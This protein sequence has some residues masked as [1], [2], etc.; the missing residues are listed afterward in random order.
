MA[1]LDFEGWDEYSLTNAPGMFN[2]NNASNNSAVG[3]G[4]LGYGRHGVGGTAAAGTG[5]NFANQ[6]AVFANFHFR[7][8]VAPGTGTFFWFV[9]AANVQV[10]LRWS[11]GGNLVLVRGTTIV[12]TSPAYVYP[13]NTWIFLQFYALIDPLVGAMEAW[14]NGVSA[15]SFAGNTRQTANTQVTGWRYSFTGNNNTHFDNL[16]VYNTA[17]AAPNARTQET[18]VFYSL[19]SGPVAGVPAQFTPVGAAANWECTDDNPPDADAT[20]VEAAAAPLTDVYDIPANAV[21][22]GSTVY[23]VANR[24]YARK[25]DAGV[26]DLDLLLR[27][28]GVNYP[29]GAPVALNTAYTIQRSVWNTD[30]NTVAAWTVSGA[31]AALPGIT[32]TA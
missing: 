18:R 6:V 31:N 2:V 24:A 20:Y 32:R 21:P 14:V 10:G 12:A 3:D 4:F 5:R 19:P 25:D 27:S 16:L 23:A 29:S 11:A 26:N 8:T 7:N 9:D 17:G 30:P 15:V 13:N 28:N 1:L 22:A